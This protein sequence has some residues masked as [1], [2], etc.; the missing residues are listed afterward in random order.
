MMRVM[1]VLLAVS[2]HIG[3]S[4]PAVPDPRSLRERPAAAIVL[5]TN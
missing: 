5:D 1:A 3:S 4:D 2:A